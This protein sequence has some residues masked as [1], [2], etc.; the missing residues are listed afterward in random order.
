[1]VCRGDPGT[2]LSLL[3][4]LRALANKQPIDIDSG[5][6]V[7]YAFAKAMA[8]PNHLCVA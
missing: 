4:F 3:S 2:L 7:L 1:M 8:I 6:S 5:E